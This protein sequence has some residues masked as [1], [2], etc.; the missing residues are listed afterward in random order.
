V[1]VVLQV[2]SRGLLV[3]GR[4]AVHGHPQQSVPKRCDVW[5]M[6]TISHQ[7]RTVL[8]GSWTTGRMLSLRGRLPRLPGAEEV[9]RFRDPA[10]TRAN[11]C[12]YLVPSMSKKNGPKY[13]RLW[14]LSALDL[15]GNLCSWANWRRS[16]RIAWVSADVEVTFRMFLCLCEYRHLL[17]CQADPLSGLVWTPRLPPGRF[18]GWEQKSVLSPEYSSVWVQKYGL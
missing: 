6:F 7:G 17:Y 8:R 13:R 12:P 14:R 1:Y 9:A 10:L 4:T 3:R 15:S 16:S 11:V 18:F 2:C 5:R